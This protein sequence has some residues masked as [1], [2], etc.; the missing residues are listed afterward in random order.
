MVSL[1]LTQSSGGSEAVTIAGN[2]VYGIE[3]YEERLN[4]FEQM[5]V[6]GST[7][8]S[9][10]GPTLIRGIILINGVSY[11]DGVALRHWL[12]DHVIFAKEKFTIGAITNL[13]LGMGLSTA[14]STSAGAV[15]DARYDGGNTLKDVFTLVAP[16]N[17]NIK[18]PYRFRRS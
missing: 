15:E 8:V 7:H 12:T 4:Q 18:F 5:T 11:T 3:F 9:D 17:Y 16:Q 14:V 13:N 6:E 10:C 1:V 2:I